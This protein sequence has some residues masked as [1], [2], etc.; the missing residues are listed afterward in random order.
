MHFTEA[1]SDLNAFTPHSKEKEE[2]RV[3]NVYYV[4]NNV[5]GIA[6]KF[7]DEKKKNPE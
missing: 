4:S 3:F 5:V 7:I 2:K 6:H 1:N